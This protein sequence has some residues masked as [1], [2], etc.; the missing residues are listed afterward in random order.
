MNKAM[1]QFLTDEVDIRNRQRQLRL[2]VSY[3]MQTLRIPDGDHLVLIFGS[4][5]ERNNRQALMH[6]VEQHLDEFD[7]DETE[8][9]LR[10]LAS[11]ASQTI[12]DQQW[13]D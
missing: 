12:Q 7:P 1:T 6:W 3:L 2:I 8:L 13:N 4:G 5:R 10:R 9:R 11:R